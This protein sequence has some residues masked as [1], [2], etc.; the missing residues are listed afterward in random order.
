VRDEGWFIVLLIDQG[1]ED[2]IQAALIIQMFCALDVFIEFNAKVGT[3]GVITSSDHTTVDNGARD[4]IADAVGK[5]IA[6]IVRRTKKVSRAFLGVGKR[7]IT[8]Q[9]KYTLVVLIMQQG[10]DVRG[11]SFA[12]MPR[13]EPIEILTGKDVV[14]ICQVFQCS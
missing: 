8:I 10:R 9:V 14:D 3:G 4:S 13:C 6:D 7:L 12:D 11:P 2:G 1:F 5:C